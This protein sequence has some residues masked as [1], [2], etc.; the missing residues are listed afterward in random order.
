MSVAVKAWLSWVPSDG[1]QVTA[2]LIFLVMSCHCKHALCHDAASDGSCKRG[3]CACRFDGYRA[4]ALAFSIMRQETCWSNTDKAIVQEWQ[5]GARGR[6]R[7][8]AAVED[9]LHAPELKDF[10][11]GMD[12]SEEKPEPIN[13][14]GRLATLARMLFFTVPSYRVRSVSLT[15]AAIPAMPPVLRGLLKAASL[16]SAL[17][18]LGKVAE[19]ASCKHDLMQRSLRHA[20]GCSSKHMAK[21]DKVDGFELHV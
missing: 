9:S 1:M 19:Q 8:V 10:L 21:P 3:W 18:L 4:Q 17:V 2:W 20:S 14:K 6:R 16:G 11:E 5:S 13:G 15:Y 7:L 12:P